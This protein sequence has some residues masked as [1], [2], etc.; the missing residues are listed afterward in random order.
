MITCRAFKNSDA[1]EV[2]N[3]VKE[4]MLTTN[5]KDYSIEYLE[6]DLK[7]L[8]AQAFIEKAK[9]FHCYVLIDDTKNKIVAVG[10]IGA[11]WGKK[12]ESSLFNIFVSPE[13]QGQGN[14]KKL[15]QVLEQDEYFKRAKRIEIP[16]SITGLG[17]YEKMGYS[18]KN[19]DNML[20]DE[21]LYRLEKYNEKQFI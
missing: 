21:Q 16:A 12:D 13:Y 9:Y 10:S 17:F 20:D 8:T 3:L 4:T 2:A 19:G 7:N 11:Y 15:I 1:D 18:F 14:G 5:I 6:N